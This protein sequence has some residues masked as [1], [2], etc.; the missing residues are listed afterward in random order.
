MDRLK[1]HSVS[2]VNENIKKITK[3]FSNTLN[4]AYIV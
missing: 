1:M 4:R 2:K 3:L